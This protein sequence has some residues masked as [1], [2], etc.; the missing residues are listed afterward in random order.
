M[1]KDARNILLDFQAQEGWT[2]GTVVDLLS[3]FVNEEGLQEK[4]TAFLNS[5]RADESGE[6][7][8]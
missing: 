5:R 2:L 8:G 4:L 7:D 1:T 3:D 6:D